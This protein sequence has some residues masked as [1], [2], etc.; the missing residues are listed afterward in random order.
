M[1]L[2]QQDENHNDMKGNLPIGLSVIMIGAVTAIAVPSCTKDT[3]LNTPSTDHG[4]ELSFRSDVPKGWFIASTANSTFTIGQGG[5]P[6]GKL[7]ASSQ[8]RVEGCF[9]VDPTKFPVFG[10]AFD[11]NLCSTSM[12]GNFCIP[13][14]GWQFNKNAPASCS[15]GGTSYYIIPDAGPPYPNK[16]ALLIRIFPSNCNMFDP[17]S[18]PGAYFTYNQTTGQWSNNPVASMRF[19]FTLNV[20]LPSYSTP[21]C[22]INNCS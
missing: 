1:L 6:K 17:F 9:C 12:P 18:T 13:H 3:K 16:K 5:C 2:M 14:G 22:C 20:P 8:G 19:C 21:P 4:G 11:C 15:S 10:K 7:Y